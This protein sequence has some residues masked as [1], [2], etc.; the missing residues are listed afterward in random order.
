VYLPFVR[1]KDET[2]RS[3]KH[4]RKGKCTKISEIGDLYCIETMSTKENR[5]SQSILLIY[6]FL[7]NK[8]FFLT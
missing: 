7:N 5:T 3:H 8:M 4:P 2:L 6:L 1:K